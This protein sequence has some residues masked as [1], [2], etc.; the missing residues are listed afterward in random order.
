[1]ISEDIK[2]EPR[3]ITLTLNETVKVEVAAY[4]LGNVAYHRTIGGTVWCVSHIA[5]G[6]GLGFTAQLERA[7]WLSRL[8]GDILPA[9]SLPPA[10]AD[11]PPPLR[12]TVHQIL[13]IWN[14]EEPDEPAPRS[15]NRK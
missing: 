15:R 7:V 10:I 14:A 9:D 4:A 13:M 8:L 11:W 2:P 6:M 5:S 1:M 3:T 12:E